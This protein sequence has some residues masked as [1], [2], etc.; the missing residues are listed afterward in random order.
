VNSSVVHFVEVARRVTDRFPFYSVADQ[1]A[2]IET[3]P[4]DDSIAFRAGESVASI[5]ADVDPPAI[6]QP[7]FWAD[8]VDAICMGDLRT[9][10]ILS[11]R[12]S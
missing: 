5:V 3:T 2:E 7:S 9:E 8:L 10:D 12:D 11:E 4:I 1:E 6:A